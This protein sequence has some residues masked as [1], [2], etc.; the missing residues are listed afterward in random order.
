MVKIPVFQEW[1]E[2]AGTKSGWNSFGWVF[3][4]GHSV[5]DSFKVNVVITNKFLNPLEGYIE[6]DDK[7][8]DPTLRSYESL[9]EV[10][11]QA[12]E[13]GERLAATFGEKS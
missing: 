10:S 4:N 3:A 13:S 11:K 12:R 5:P 7:G 8:A 9:D 6:F 1:F 2:D